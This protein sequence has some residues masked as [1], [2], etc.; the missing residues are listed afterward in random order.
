MRVLFFP[1]YLGGGYGHIGRCQSLAEELANRG[2]EASF[3][4]GGPHADRLQAT[5]KVFRLQEPAVPRSK[6]TPAAYTVISGMNYQ[7]L[8]DGLHSP[9]A[10]R[11]ALREQLGVVKRFRPDV[12]VADSWPL[13]SVLKGMTGLPLVQITR[14]S[15]YPVAPTLIWWQPVPAELVP[16]DPR[17]VFNPLLRAWGL[18]PIQRAEDLLSGDRYL[19][20]SLPAL[21]PI[22]GPLPETYYI[23]PLVRAKPAVETLTEVPSERQQKRI[24]VTT[25]GGAENVGGET[26][27]RVLLEA[28]AGLPVQAVVST[29]NR[30]N[31]RSLPPAPPNVQ[32][33]AWADG[34]QLARQSDLVVFSGGYGT[35]MDLVLA[36]TPGLVIPFHSE[37]ESNGRRL[38]AA[39][40]AQ[41]LLPAQSEAVVS[42]H[43]WGGKRFSTMHYPNFDLDVPRLR[44]A[45]GC[46]LED[47]RL[48]EGAMR[49]Q[50]QAGQ[51][52][53][54]LQAADLVEEL[55]A[56]G[57]P[58][59]SNWQRLPWRQK[60]LLRH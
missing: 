28:L 57:V 51:T 39:R 3:A 16:P 50:Q 9:A 31:P 41:V 7:L 35:S 22:P 4:L 15:I 42:W 8:R 24:Y 1:S 21:D 58:S 12:L 10:I 43:T 14:A 38:E 45:I 55:V 2:W 6:P 49:L 27:Y 19:V 46:A 37:Q 54:A 13:A 17:P 59:Q 25:G 5:G 33:V 26:F 44:E 52:R 60:F 56:K 32:L 36:G 40:A 53:G 20:P 11:R 47:G 48:K 29:G 18:P 34:P 23:G 30:L